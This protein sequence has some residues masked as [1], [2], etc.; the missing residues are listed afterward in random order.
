[1]PNKRALLIG[2]NYVGTNAA[3]RG[4]VNDARNVRAHLI[5]QRRDPCE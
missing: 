2:I 1:M 3:L 4:C 5:N